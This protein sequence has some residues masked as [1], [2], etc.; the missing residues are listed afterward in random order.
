M[1]G[2]VVLLQGTPCAPKGFMNGCVH[3]KKWRLVACCLKVQPVLYCDTFSASGDS[4]GMM[5]RVVVQ[6]MA[7]RLMVQYYIDAA[8]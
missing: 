4:R 3:C 1:L 6:L 2:I 7:V 8:A 5:D